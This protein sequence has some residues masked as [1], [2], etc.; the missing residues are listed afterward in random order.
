LT[1]IQGLPILERDDNPLLLERA[2]ALVGV[3][4]EL[5]QTEKETERLA[6]FLGLNDKLTIYVVGFYLRA[7]DGC[8]EIPLVEWW[9]SFLDSLQ[10]PWIAVS[11]R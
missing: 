10:H 1:E 2:R 7:A 3:I 6:T 11:A 9:G 4:A 8:A 5:V